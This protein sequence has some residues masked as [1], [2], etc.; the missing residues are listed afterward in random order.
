[1][2]RR[3]DGPTLSGLADLPPGLGLEAAAR[4]LGI[5][6]SN[7]YAL[8]RAEQFPVPLIRIGKLYRVPTSAVLRLLGVAVPEGHR[9]PSPGRQRLYKD[10]ELGLEVLG[11]AE[12]RYP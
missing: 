10:F 2:N 12:R 3:N 8:A 4:L 11:G 7:A 9:P 6:R 1:M 5:G